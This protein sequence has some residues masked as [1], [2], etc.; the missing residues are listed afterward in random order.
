[1]DDNQ[2]SHSHHSSSLKPLFMKVWVVLRYS[3]LILQ[4]KYGGLEADS[5][6]L[7]VGAVLVIVPGPVQSAGSLRLRRWHLGLVCDRFSDI[8]FPGDDVGDQPG[9]V[10]VHQL[11]LAMGAVNRGIDVLRRLPKILQ[12]GDLLA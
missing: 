9:T 1:M 12:N 6:L 5:V 4:R 2:D 10:F 3:Q 7:Y 8:Q 11:D